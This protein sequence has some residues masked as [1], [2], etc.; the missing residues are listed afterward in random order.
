KGE[1]LRQKMTHGAA[2]PAVTMTLKHKVKRGETLSSIAAHYGVRAQRLAQ[3][4][5]IGRR[6]PLRTGMLLTVPAGLTTP[7]PAALDPADPRG[8]TSYVPRRT[9]GARRMVNGQSTGV[10]RRTVMV[11]RGATLASIPGPND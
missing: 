3:V 5:G 1:V 4:N 7:A 8:S 11:H 2:L 10:R 6:R 9:I